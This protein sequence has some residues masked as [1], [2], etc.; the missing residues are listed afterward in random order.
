[1]RR[2]S[3]W[4]CSSCSISTA[5]TKLVL[6]ASLAKMPITLERRFIFSFT[7]HTS[8]CDIHPLQQVGAPEL[9]PVLRREVTE[10]QHVLPSLVHELG[11]FGEALSR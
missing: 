5:P 10:G 7:E 4:Q 9:F 3:S 2:P 1:M 6:A 11:G 8:L